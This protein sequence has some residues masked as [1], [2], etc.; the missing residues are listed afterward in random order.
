MGRMNGIRKAAAA[1]GVGAFALGLS[2]MGA[3][4]AQ[5]AGSYQVVDEC[6]FQN[7]QVI[8]TGDYTVGY[9][10][11]Y[12][13]GYMARDTWAVGDIVVDSPNP[14]DPERFIVA[15]GA[16]DQTTCP[17]EPSPTPTEEPAQQPAVKAP[18]KATTTVQSPSTVTAPATS[19]TAETPEA[20]G[21]PSPEPSETVEPTP[22]ETPVT[23]AAAD[24]QTTTGESGGNLIIPIGGAVAIAGAL[25]GLGYT[26]SKLG[27]LKR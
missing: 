18:A 13:D 21:A 11:H 25:T 3:T 12:Q 20:T 2:I 27:W 4:S 24:T 26:A 15:Q 10:G 1:V 17:P 14:D 8:V 23:I 5:A 16:F 9:S 19:T 7:D 6:G 22:E